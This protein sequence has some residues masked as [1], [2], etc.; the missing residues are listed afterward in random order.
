[1]GSEGMPFDRVS[2]RCLTSF[3]AF[4]QRRRIAQQR[5]TARSNKR[6][7]LYPM[8]FFQIYLATSVLTFA[9][10]PWP[11]PVTD[12]WQ[13]YLFLILAQT[14]LL[15]GYLKAIRKQPRSASTK[16]RV[17]LAVT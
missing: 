2:D 5:V 15:A 1:M 10:G 6:I 8:I 14:A 4:E 13:L 12:S 9:F 17:P 16:L 3:D 7:S 11:W